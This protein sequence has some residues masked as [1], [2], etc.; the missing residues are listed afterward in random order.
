M[1]NGIKE[2]CNSCNNKT[3][4]FSTG[5]LCKVTKEK[6]DYSGRCDNYDENAFQLRK[7]ENEK[8]YRSTFHIR[9]KIIAIFSLV[10]VIDILSKLISYYTDN[11]YDITYILIYI[12]SF[13]VQA[14]LLYGTYL[15]LDKIKSALTYLA[16]CGII[17][18]CYMTFLI[19]NSHSFLFH[20]IYISK[21][22]LYAYIVRL[23][24]F[25]FEFKRFFEYQHK[26][27]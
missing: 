9:Q 21:L 11:Y 25:D 6:P 22:L 19:D 17:V 7:F 2:L 1:E 27:R 23:L 24:L 26:N 5:I 16:I 18:G 3:I 8:E 14:G 10:L 20:T 4:D 12:I 13:S 15:G